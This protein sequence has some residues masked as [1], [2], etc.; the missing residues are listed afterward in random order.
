VVCSLGDGLLASDV[1]ACGWV[2]RWVVS[3][4]RCVAGG[5]VR[6]RVYVCVRKCVFSGERECVRVCVCVAVPAAC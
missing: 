1:R 6:V 3:E 4:G 2:G 5:H